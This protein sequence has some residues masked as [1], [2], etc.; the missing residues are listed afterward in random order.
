MA[1]QAAFKMKRFR[2]SYAVTIR[3]TME[4]EAPD[5]VTA[6]AAIMADPDF[7]DIAYPGCCEMTDWEVR[8]VREVEP[9][10]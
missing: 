8:D 7:P 6:H 3:G 4:V 1:N 5:A 9:R 10:R 2:V